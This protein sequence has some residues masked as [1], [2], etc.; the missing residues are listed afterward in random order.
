MLI[1]LVCWTVMK[2]QSFHHHMCSFWNQVFW[3]QTQWLRPLFFQ[4]SL[5]QVTPWGLSVSQ[6]ISAHILS[7]ISHM[8]LCTV[9]KTQ[10][11]GLLLACQ[12]VNSCKSI[13][14]LN[15]H[16]IELWSNISTSQ[17][18]LYCLFNALLLQMITLEMKVQPFWVNHFRQ[19]PHSLNLIWVVNT[20]ILL[21]KE[22]IPNTLHLISFIL[23]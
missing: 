21:E 13:Q 14:R 15:L 10:R 9:K 12:V 11:N 1:W 4:L 18:F 3:K 2:N 8:V 7:D 6:S 16:G 23:I 19:T 17:H 5:F 20:D 22:Y